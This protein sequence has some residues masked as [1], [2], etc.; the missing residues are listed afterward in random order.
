MAEGASTGGPEL[1]P[2]IYLITDAAFA[3]FLPVA[4]AAL[5]AGAALVQLRDKSLPARELLRLA[6][7][8]LPIC[9]AHQAKLLVNDRGDIALAASADGVHLPADGLAVPEARALLGPSALVGVSCHTADEVARAGSSGA[10]FCVFGPVWETPGKGPPRGVAALAAAARASSIPLF[11]LGGVDARSAPLAL[12]A[13]AHGVACIRA[14]LAAVDPG[15][16]ARAL[17]NALGSRP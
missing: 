15:A 4:L 9:R 17:W 7:A 13:G 8:L 12:A 5:P 10:S 2:R 1:L 11:A 3:R 16:A 14:V 6:R